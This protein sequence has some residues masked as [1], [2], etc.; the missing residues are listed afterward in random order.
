MVCFCDAIRQ[1]SL[2]MKPI[3]SIESRYLSQSIGR[4]RPTGI[5][6]W[7]RGAG[8]MTPQFY[9]ISAKTDTKVDYAL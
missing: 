9:I 4:L 7:N 6:N 3:T 1:N 5:S 8:N 2:S